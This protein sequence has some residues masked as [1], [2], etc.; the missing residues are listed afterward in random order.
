VNCNQE[1]C[2]ELW[3]VINFHCEIEPANLLQYYLYFV[4]ILLGRK[5]S[6]ISNRSISKNVY[7]VN[8]DADKCVSE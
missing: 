6:A 7:F 2:I 3:S 8:K 1:L 5:E 4:Q